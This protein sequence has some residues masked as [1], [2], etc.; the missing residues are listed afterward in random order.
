MLHYPSPPLV[1]FLLPSLFC[2]V[3]FSSHSSSGSRETSQ[4]MLLRRFFLPR[5][6]FFPF[7]V[8]FIDL[9]LMHFE[10][11]SVCV[12]GKRGCVPGFTLSVGILLWRG[13]W[14]GCL[15]KS[16]RPKESHSSEKL[17]DFYRFW[18]LARTQIHIYTLNKTVTTHSSFFPSLLL[19]SKKPP[20]KHESA[21][22]VTLQEMWVRPSTTVFMSKHSPVHRY[23]LS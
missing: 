15:K 21:L 3:P 18:N 13:R 12:G 4:I 1:L 8:F 22:D 6:L 2:L 19:R 16:V 14:G 23:A 20:Q 7:L 9:A 11:P 17:G 10:C 5:S